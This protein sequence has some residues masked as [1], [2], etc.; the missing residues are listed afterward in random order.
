[1]GIQKEK[2]KKL[3]LNFGRVT[4]K[5]IER[6]VIWK[7]G[8]ED[9]RRES[10]DTGHTV[11]CQYSRK[12]LIYRKTQFPLPECTVSRCLFFKTLMSL[13]ISLLSLSLSSFHVSGLSFVVISALSCRPFRAV[14]PVERYTTGPLQCVKLPAWKTWSFLALLAMRKKVHII[15]KPH[16][17]GHWS[18]HLKRFGFVII[19]KMVAK[20][21]I[22]VFLI[23][24]LIN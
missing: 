12:V 14:S 20:K 23:Q 19:R 1:M 16:W 8:R 11:D 4:I 15:K 2:L 10:D 6:G 7:M 5:D 9:D 13:S 22:D 18:W 17:S 21:H 24:L 3:N